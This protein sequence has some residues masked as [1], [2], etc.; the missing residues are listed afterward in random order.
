LTTRAAGAVFLFFF[1]STSKRGQAGATGCGRGDALDR[2]NSILGA[3]RQRGDIYAV[4]ALRPTTKVG[5]VC[6]GL[7]AALVV[8]GVSVY[9]KHRFFP[10]P[11]AEAA[12][13]M[14]A[15]GDLLQFIAVFVVAALAPI[16]IALY[17]LRQV[18]RFWSALQWSAALFSLTGWLALLVFVAAR[19]STSS[20]MLLD[21][22]R[23]GMMPLSALV[24]AAC[25]ALA[26]RARQ[27]WLLFAAACSDGLMFVGY[28]F[29]SEA[30]FSLIG[31]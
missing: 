15:F 19:R 17:W 4:I 26:P 16:S 23:I 13:G 10:L 7:A 21:H 6:A 28:L 22:A 9:A 24:L 8:A 3:C 5:I 1:F 11:P 2:S 20:W 18:E 31:R 14:A 27:R 30:I 12:G 29:A 25:A